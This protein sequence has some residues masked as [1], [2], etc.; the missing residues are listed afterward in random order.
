MKATKVEMRALKRL[1]GDDGCNNDESWWLLGLSQKVKLVMPLCPHL[2]TLINQTVLTDNWFLVLN[3]W[4]LLCQVC[5]ISQHPALSKVF[6][7]TNR[8]SV[9]KK[10][11]PAILI[12]LKHVARWYSLINAAWTPAKHQ[13]LNIGVSAKIWRLKASQAQWQAVQPA[14]VVGLLDTFQNHSYHSPLPD[15]RPPSTKTHLLAI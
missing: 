2:Y 12:H 9:T 11:E 7:Q 6:F 8:S 1:G 4:I 13:Q 15:A 10:W 3:K 5:F 14:S